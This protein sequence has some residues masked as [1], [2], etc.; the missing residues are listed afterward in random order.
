M[1][2]SNLSPLISKGSRYPFKH[3]AITNMKSAPRRKKIYRRAVNRLLSAGGAPMG[4]SLKT[5]IWPALSAPAESII[6]RP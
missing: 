4:A 2:E 5:S 1:A 3:R 6:S